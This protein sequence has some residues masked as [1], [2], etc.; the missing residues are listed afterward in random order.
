MNNI[1]IIS[2]II[3][4][5]ILIILFSTKKFSQETQTKNIFSFD[6]IEPIFE[7]FLEPFLNQPNDKNYE[8]KELNELNEGIIKFKS[9]QPINFTQINLKDINEYL[10]N[11]KSIQ[12]YIPI[13][14]KWHINFIPKI[15]I[16]HQESNKYYVPEESFLI[17]INNSNEYE[18]IIEDDELINQNILIKVS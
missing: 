10:K 16:K 15:L 18:F 7:S 8:I 6:K 4:I 17:K 1:I 5:I 11:N 12:V 2:I 9:E 14:F 13:N 3:I